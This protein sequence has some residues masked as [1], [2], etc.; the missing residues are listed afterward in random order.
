MSL[1]VLLEFTLTQESLADAPRVMHETLQATRAFPGCLSVE[2]LRHTDDPARILFLE[3]WES[4]EADAT[5]RAWRI[6]PEGAS[7]LTSMFAA[8][9]SLS[10][11]TI[12]SDI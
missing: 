8:P 6:T 2:V 4:A 5:Y 3:R 10:T 11:F 1:T 9:P 7:E 12:E